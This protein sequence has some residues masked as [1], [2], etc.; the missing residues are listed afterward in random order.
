M[1]AR[2]I[3]SGIALAVFVFIMSEVLPKVGAILE[4]IS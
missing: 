2:L 4:V 3:P 1:I